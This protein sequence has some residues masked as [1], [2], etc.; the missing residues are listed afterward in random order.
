MKRLECLAFSCN[1]CKRTSIARP[2]ETGSVYQSVNPM[3]LQSLIQ[4][5]MLSWETGFKSFFP[6]IKSQSNHNAVNWSSCVWWVIQ[7]TDL[8]TSV[9]EL[10]H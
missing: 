1:W 8:V 7:Q 5:N 10:F 2:I 6:Y 4:P 9:L 3:H